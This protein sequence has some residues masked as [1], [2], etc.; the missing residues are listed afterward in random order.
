[1]KFSLILVFAFL[2]AFAQ[3]SFEFPEPLDV[4]PLTDEQA[5][6]LIVEMV[7]IEPIRVPIPVIQVPV[8][9]LPEVLV[10]NVPGISVATVDLICRGVKGMGVQAVDVAT[11][12]IVARAIEMISVDSARVAALGV[13]SSGVQGVSVDTVSTVVRAIEMISVEGS[14]VATPSIATAGSL[15]AVIDSAAVYTVSPESVRIVIAALE[16]MDCQVVSPAIVAVALRQ[17]AAGRVQASVVDVPG[18]T[19]ADSR[20]PAIR[21]FW[22]KCREIFADQR[23]IQHDRGLDFDSPAVKKWLEI[24]ER[25]LPPPIATVPL[26]AGIRMI[27]ELRLLE[28]GTIPPAAEANLAVYAGLGY[29]ACLITVY[30]DETPAGLLSLASLIRSAGMAPWFAWAGPESLSTTIFHDPDQI[31]RLLTPLARVS[32]G[33]LCAWRRTSAHLVEQDPQYIEHIASI[34]RKANPAIPIVGESYYGQTWKNEPHVNQAG[35]EAR[36]NTPRNPSGI[37]IAGISTR[38]YNIENMLTTV[39]GRWQSISRLGL[40]LGERP[41]Y[42]SSANNGR[43][44][45]ENLQIKHELERRFLRAGCH[46]TVTIHG[47][48]SDRGAAPQASDN[49]G[50]N[51]I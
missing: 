33:Y 45:R 23:M 1:M 29:N 22:Q 34:V 48:G 37:L 50:E 10:A 5:A 35:W 46:G 49:L 13:S 20:I 47:D 15:Q 24:Y 42:A 14:R 4:T 8:I 6:E 17:I 40:V 16:A 25:P 2:T 7:A 26:P 51:E 21:D 31:A 32:N 41:Y 28:S 11:V 27:A 39:F 36:D 30:G 9:D 38:G 44:W 12:S 19:L 18:I 3:T 43:T